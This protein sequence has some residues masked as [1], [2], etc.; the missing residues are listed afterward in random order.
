MKAKIKSLEE[1]IRQLQE[2]IESQRDIVKLMTPK[3]SAMNKKDKEIEEMIGSIR[4]KEEDIL[5]IAIAIK[6]KDRTIEEMKIE[7]NKKDE[8]MKM[9]I[10][11]TKDLIKQKGELRK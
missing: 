4:Q 8:N 3:A 6:Q 10:N 1:E 9:L 7:C 11:Q 5:E 2:D